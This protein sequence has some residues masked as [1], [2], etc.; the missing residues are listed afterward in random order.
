MK[1]IHGYARMLVLAVVVLF[2]AIAGAP[3]S[4]L[5]AA[6]DAYTA[7]S[8]NLA[9]PAA[10]QASAP[11]AWQGVTLHSPGSDSN[12]ATP[13][14]PTTCS[15]STLGDCEDTKIT[16]PSGVSPSTL[17]VKVTWQHSAWQAF[18][19]V[20]DPAGNLHGG[21]GIG[22]DSSSYEKGCGNQTTM[23][24][25]ELAI[26]DPQPGAWTVRVAA[27]NIHNEAYTG[28]AVLTHSHDLSYAKETLAQ[29]T[30]HLTRTQ[31]VNIVFAGWK[32]TSDD[33]SQLQGN[34]TTEFRPSVA[35]KQSADGGDANDLP[36]SGLIQHET[37][38]Y[39]ATDS[40]G[41]PNY[42]ASGNVPYFEPLRFQM[43]YHFL[44]A[45]D[46]WTQD[47][48]S[49]MKSATTVGH[50]LNQSHVPETTVPAPFEGAY[51]AKYNST[52]AALFGGPSVTDT[53]T[54]DE[55]DG[56]NVEDWIQNHRFDARY[57]AAFTDLKTGTTIGGAFLNPDPGAIRDNFWN[58]NGK[59]AVNLDSDPQ[60]ANTG[61]TFFLL[62]TFTPSY[63]S[64]YFRTDHYHSWWTAS[65]VV[66]PDYG[67]PAFVD[68]GRG[69]GG[70][71]RFSILDLGAAPSTYERANW[72]ATTVAPDGGS[73][74]FDPPIWDYHNNPR[75]NG[76]LP[77][78][79]LQAGGNTLG[80]VM[81]WEIT[82]GIAFKYV[83]AYLY[84]PIPNDVYVMAT[85]Q[86]VDH[87]SLP[88]EGDLYSVDISKVDIGDYARQELSTAAPYASF[89]PG[90]S[91]NRVL[92]CAQYH[93][94]E[95][96]N[97]NYAQLLVGQQVG[98]ALPLI[99]DPNCNGS[100]ALETPDGLQQAIED[101]KA[102][103]TGEAV[104]I[105]G[106]TTFDYAVDVGYIRDYIDE[107]RSQF[108]PLYNGAFTVPV[109]N[110]MFPQ[111]WDAALPL[112]VGGIAAAANNGEGWGQI[113]NVNDDLVPYQAIQCAQSSPAAPGCNGIP[114]T[115]RHNY[116]LTYVMI[117]E[118]SHFLGLPH[119]HDGTA[120][121]QKA[122]NG[123]WQYYYSMLKWLYDIS[124]SPTT[125]AGDYSI[126]E[127]IDQDRLMYGHTAEYLKQ[128]QDWMA[129]NYFRDAMA[130]R[131]QP[132]A[133]TL[134]RLKLMRQ[135]VNLS[136]ALF[137]RGDYLHAMY[138][139]RNAA[140]HAQGVN[141]SASTPHKMSL[142]A[143]ASH[144]GAIFAIHPAAVYNP[145]QASAPPSTTVNAA[146]AAA[147]SGT[148]SGQSQAPKTSKPGAGGSAAGLANT[149]AGLNAMIALVAA[150]GLILILVAGA[151]LIFW[152]ERSAATS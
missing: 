12:V 77:L 123:Q 130:G 140:L 111:K 36:G 38:H 24:F 19:Y 116:G 128:A 22:C 126:Y 41:D 84:R 86:I 108:A 21:G 133:E 59:A 52:D 56:P 34:L 131:T 113:D 28:E 75:W 6:A 45:S 10:G 136:S 64:N 101:G 68:N 44:E 1:S 109:L 5:H 11:C 142:Q 99:P 57:K 80:Q 31:R 151:A 127:N 149:G 42:N 48:F 69:W 97:A 88:S 82:Q 54:V 110:V 121:V 65:H 78:D 125:Y 33:L 98:L 94:P 55:I 13:T 74:A 91:V 139:M 100:S 141:Q 60:G 95:V 29:L 104:S 35:E 112:L 87:Y 71:Y 138:A 144:S 103:G 83:G 102:H 9:A 70:R 120:S 107:H 132:S 117:H 50:S 81:G 73:A 46:Q 39:T 85:T 14:S 72:V 105:A 63:A 49:E 62:D 89:I 143:A 37:S 3:V 147:N 66:D 92:G 122:G 114:D 115:F 135:D 8:C 76:S 79:P 134:R 26:A 30:A 53:S 93:V 129:D 7:P 15:P 27:V 106:Q 124:A 4:G 146:P 67:D 148:A 58:K 150:S 137:Q 145:E 16:V 119:P 118:S 2:A 47:L 17:Y 43:D 61:V 51:L 18:M 23:P 96:G 20:I 32:P 25:D 90:P 152:K 40:A